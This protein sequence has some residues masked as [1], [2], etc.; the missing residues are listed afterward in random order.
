[1]RQRALDLVAPRP[2]GDDVVPALEASLP[3]AKRLVEQCAA[4]GIRARLG[5]TA[6][7]SSG[8]CTP[9][10][11]VMVRRDDLPRV[12]GLLQRLWLEAAAREGTLDEEFLEKLRT[13]AASAS[14]DPPCPACGTAAPLVDGACSDCGLQ[15]A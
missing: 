2:S 9:K 11:Q 5:R 8:G 4:E 12:Q 13:A 7:C 10:A 14:N 1:M 3:D 6:T 15:L